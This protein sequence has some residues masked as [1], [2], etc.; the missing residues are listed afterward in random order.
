M[1]QKNNKYFTALKTN[2]MKKLNWGNRMCITTIIE[3]IIFIYS[4][5]PIF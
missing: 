4:C 1:K 5:D 3:F 2:D